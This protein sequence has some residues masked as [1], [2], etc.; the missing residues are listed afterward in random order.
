[1][2]SGRISVLFRS[3]VRAPAD[4]ARDPAIDTRVVARRLRSG[5]ALCAFD[6]DLEIVEW[7]DAAEALTGI[8][9]REAVGRPCWE[10]LGGRG[11]DGSLVCHRGCSGARLALT[12][13]PLKPQ[14]LTIRTGAGRRRVIAT[15]VAA[16][17]LVIHLLEPAPE[18]EEEAAVRPATLTP[19][20]LQVLHL[21]A[22]GLSV[23]SI[24]SRLGV[25]EATTRNHVHGVLVDLDAHSQLEAVSKAREQGFFSAGR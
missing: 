3:A 13:W 1:M 16:D 8:P 25:T 23:R 22:A 6:G 17:D 4:G 9:A 18:R 7:N 2:F 10:V 24:A 21:L 14:A 5:S 20:R 19:R 15:T 12:G 11:D